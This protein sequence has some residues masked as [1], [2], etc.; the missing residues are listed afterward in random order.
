MA[1]TIELGATYA[2]KL[3]MNVGVAIAHTDYL[4]SSGTT[5]VL[6]KIN[7]ADGNP[8]L[9][10]VE[11]DDLRLELCAGVEVLDVTDAEDE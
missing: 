6:F 11:I 5:T 8:Q 9:A 10:E 2:D 3:T 1:G 4:T 7:A